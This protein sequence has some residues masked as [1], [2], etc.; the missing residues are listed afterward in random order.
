MVDGSGL[1]DRNRASAEALV[2][3]LQA[4]AQIPE[5]DVFRRSLAVSGVSGTLKNRF[6]NTSAQGIVSAKT[7]TITGV[8]AL[9]GY[10]APPNSAPLV[11]SL[12]ANSS[13]SAGTVRSAVDDVVVLLT[14]LRSCS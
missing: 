1:A 8:V 3:T 7:G 14:R 2:Q 11:F 4:M 13:A 5:A 6:R 10:V 9:S 12:I